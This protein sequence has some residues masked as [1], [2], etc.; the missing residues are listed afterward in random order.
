MG[1]PYLG[2]MNCTEFDEAYSQGRSFVLESDDGF[3]VAC[4]FLL[5]LSGVLLARGEDL[6]R[7]L[8][9]VVA[10]CVAAVATFVITQDSDSTSMCEVRLAVAGVAGVLVAV[11]TLCLFKAGLFVLGAAGFGSIAHFIYEA[12]PALSSLDPPFVLFGRSGYYFIALGIGVVIGAVATQRQR[13]QFVRIS[14]SLL[15]GAGVATTVHLIADR[16]Q[17]TLPPAAL[18]AIVLVCTLGGVYVQYR[19]KRPKRRKARDAQSKREYDDVVE[20]N[21][22]FA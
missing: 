13:V 22:R 14:S 8:G 6:V 5:L 3:A 4:G 12:I 20:K 10:G 21:D 17:E 1:T 9:A 2:V 18:L 15:G 19:I 16:A 7:P 11:A